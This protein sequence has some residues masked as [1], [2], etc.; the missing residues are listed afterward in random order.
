VSRDSLRFEILILLLHLL[1]ALAV[2]AVAWPEITTP[3]YLW[4]R[5]MLLYRDVK[6]L[7]TPGL[8]GLLA[9]AFRVFGPHTLVVR[10][11]AIAGPLVGH[12]LVL[13]QTRSLRPWRRALVSAFYVVC[14]F[15][16][17]GNAVW[18]VVLMAALSLPIASE[19]TRGRWLR[20]G[21]WIGAAILM[22]QTAAFVLVVAVFVLLARK[23]FRAIPPLLIGAALPYAAALAAFT[24]LGAAG[25]MILWTVLVPF[26][27]QEVTFAPGAF[28]LGVLAVCFLPTI[29]AAA[30]ETTPRDPSA[31]W[32]LA[33]AFG[34][35]LLC[36][37]NFLLLQTVAALPCLAVGAAR[38]LEI[39]PPRVS[40]WV[41][42]GLFVFTVSRATILVAGTSLDGRVRFWNEDPDFNALIERL[43]RFPEDSRV[44]SEL[45]DNVLPR[46]GRLPPG[47]VWVHPWLRWYFGIENVRERVLQAARE[48]GTIWVDYRTGLPGG[49]RVG[50]FAIQRIG[51]GGEQTCR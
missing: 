41:A 39:V 12:A 2:R 36:Y 46:A 32:L 1:L 24:L 21:L 30:L 37:P 25:E 4:S 28:T 43:R 35:T 6:F 47:R 9:L 8:I 15:V 44:H 3:A 27:V 49:E 29:A 22:K 45:W 17:D 40:R 19:L 42:A 10:A 20:A 11:F 31:A 16:A 7:H 23:S 34:F 14:L 18:P 50:P 51:G 33:V 5:G 13:R 38:L 26:Q 48:P